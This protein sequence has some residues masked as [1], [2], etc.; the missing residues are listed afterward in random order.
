M[1]R[2]FTTILLSLWLV[3]SSVLYGTMAVAETSRRTLSADEIKAAY[4]FNFAKFIDWPDE[5]FGDATS[6]LHICFIGGES[7]EKTFRSLEGKKVKGKSLQV[8]NLTQAQ[9]MGEC[10]ILF[11]GSDQI[12]RWPQIQ[13]QIPQGGLLTVSDGDGFSQD[14]GMINFS[15]EQN[16]IRFII[17]LDNTQNAGLKLSSQLLQ[18][19]EVVRNTSQGGAE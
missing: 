7:V 9:D 16:R 1:F 6:P 4:L 3:L 11:I 10:H 14:G 17:N 19:A 15:P 18:L 2:R 5:T 8:R 12:Q 13:K